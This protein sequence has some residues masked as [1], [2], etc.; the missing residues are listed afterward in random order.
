MLV[1]CVILSK[2]SVHVIS[3]QMSTQSPSKAVLQQFSVHS[4]CSAGILVT[5]GQRKGE[6]MGIEGRYLKLDLRYQVI[7]WSVR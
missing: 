5:K 3:L 6:K 4:L 2:I 7:L 1:Y